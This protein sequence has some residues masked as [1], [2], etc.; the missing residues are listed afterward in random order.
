MVF[1][2]EVSQVRN[3]AEWILDGKASGGGEP[4]G[5][6]LEEGPGEANGCEGSREAGRSMEE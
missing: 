6:Q 3:R 2:C 4:A 1:Q 5:E